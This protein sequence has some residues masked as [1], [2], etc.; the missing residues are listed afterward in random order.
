MWNS[1]LSS[2]FAC[3]H[4][5]TTFPMT[6]KGSAKASRPGTYVTCLDCGQELA[7][8]WTRMQIGEPLL[9]PVPGVAAPVPLNAHR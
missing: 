7:Y 3:R 4:E 8:D 9:Q 5:N 6:P 2:L 1:M